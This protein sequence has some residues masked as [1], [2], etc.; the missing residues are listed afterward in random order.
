MKFESIKNQFKD[1]K[2]PL[3][4]NS[5]Y[6]SL[7]SLTMAVAGF[8][9][10]SISAK[11]YPPESVGIASAVISAINIVFIASFLGMN[12]SLIRF[13]PEY[14]EHSAGTALILTSFLSLCLSLLYWL[15]IGRSGKFEDISAVD[16]LFLFVVLSMIETMYNVFLT[17]GIAMRKAKHAFVQSILFAM[18]FIFLFLLRPFGAKGIIASFGLGLALGL[19]YA[20]IKI[21]NIVLT[22]DRKF[23]RDSFKFSLGN[24]IANIA[25]ATPL[26]IMPTVV[27]SILGEEWTAYYYISFSVGN[28]LMLIPNSLNTSFFVEGSYGL[29]DLENSFKKVLMLSYLYLAIV[30]IGIWAFGG[31]ILG[32][33]GKGY[34]QGLELLRLVALGGFFMIF[35]DFTV[36]VLN[37]QKKIQEIVVINVLKAVLLLGLSYLLIPQFK[38]TGIGWAWV[39][40]Y[41][42][43]SV[44]G[45]V[46]LR[47]RIF[48]KESVSFP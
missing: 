27:L 42:V 36:T 43:L 33:F 11:I 10:W 14:K 26:Y 38:I 8:F 41:V 6:I 1:L 4:A 9:F 5:L 7:S 3:Y 46:L 22:V 2:K 13:Y 35:V 48:K 45:A 15:V 20:V 32:F 28:M 23:L 40:T 44:F 29:S 37:I 24:Y 12:F 16:L 34:I 39:I 17:Y 21:D 18:R 31:L 19:F 47:F 30:N 25:N